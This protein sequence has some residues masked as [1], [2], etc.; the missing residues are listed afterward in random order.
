PAS[1]TSSEN[2]LAGLQKQFDAANPQAMLVVQATHKN[3]DGVL[4]ATASVIV[5]SAATDWDLAAVQKAVQDVVAPGLTA[6]ALG[7]HWRDIKDAGGYF[8]LDGLLPL[9]IA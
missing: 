7:V 2:V 3:H 9:E 6:S 1:R 4:L 8:E 5:I